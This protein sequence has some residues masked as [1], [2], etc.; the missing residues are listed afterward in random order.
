MN[1]SK[2]FLLISFSSCAIHSF[3]PNLISPR[4]APKGVLSLLL[5]YNIIIIITKTRFLP[6]NSI[7]FTSRVYIFSKRFHEIYDNSKR[8]LCFRQ[9]LNRDLVHGVFWHRFCS[10]EDTI[11]KF[12]ED[13]AFCLSLSHIGRRTNRSLLATDSLTQSHSR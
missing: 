1:N 6:G 11:R 2:R 9:T 4:K 10:S 8:K 5:P 3:A 13:E 7:L 12:A